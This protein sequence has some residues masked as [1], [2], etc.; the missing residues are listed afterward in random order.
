VT[1]VLACAVAAVVGL[2]LVARALVPPRRPLG[3][4]LDALLAPPAPPRPPAVGLAARAGEALGVLWGA[5]ATRW[6][7]LGRDLEVTGDT[8]EAHLGRSVLCAA[9]GAGLVAVLAFVLAAGGVVVGPVV[10]VWAAVVVACGGA[11]APTLVA[12]S[13]AEERRAEMRATLAGVCD[14]A[15]VVLAGGEGVE[16]A[17]GAALGAGS[18]W[19]FGELRGAAARARVLRHGPWAGIGALGERYGVVEAVELGAAMALAAEEGAK[20]REALVAQA[21]VLRRRAAAADEAVAGSATE[22]MSFPVAAVLI[23][24]LLLIGYP[25]LVRL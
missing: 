4:T 5:D 23:G 13:Q 7:R 25:A 3:A 1:L 8:I 16:A 21:G 2:G 24:F 20:L 17:L 19:A 18:G 12:H 6:A 14:L 22:R 10:I 15:A 9:G 11:A